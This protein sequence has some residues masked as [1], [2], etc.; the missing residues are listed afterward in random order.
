MTD[1]CPHPARNGHHEEYARPDGSSFCR[2]CGAEIL[3]PEDP[4]LTA[5]KWN[6]LRRA[7]LG[8]NLDI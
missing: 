5:M 4:E 6:D 7:L 8:E 3:P 1:K 2:A